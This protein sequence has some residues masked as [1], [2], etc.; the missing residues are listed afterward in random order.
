MDELII[1]LSIVI[2]I[3]YLYMYYLILSK[4]KNKMKN[5]KLFHNAILNVV[6]RTQ[7]VEKAYNQL[8]AVYNKWQQET[9]NI[10]DTTLL[11]L[12]EK[13]IFYYETF[14]DEKFY[15]TFE[16]KKD[17]NISAFLSCICQYIN[18]N[19]P[20]TSNNPKEATH[21][22]HIKRALTTS[23]TDLG[24]ATLAQL[25]SEL[26]NKDK[27]LQK[28][29]KENQTATRLSILGLILTL[30]FGIISIVQNIS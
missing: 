2:I 5:Y 15:K 9:G 6:N 30:F 27:L 3:I 10:N 16:V 29:Q 17:N 28:H 25:S 26:Q 23:N 20:F 21:L 12:L 24:L 11:D 19:Y 18:N 8:N 14:S 1:L 4:S 7:S 22:S 13:T